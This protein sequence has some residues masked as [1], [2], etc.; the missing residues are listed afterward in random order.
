MTRAQQDVPQIPLRDGPAI[1]QLGYGTLALQPDREHSDANAEITASVVAEALRAGYRHLDSAQSYG[2]ERGVGRAIAESGIARDELYVA[3]KLAN[4]HHRPD[5]VR[6]SF[7]QTLERLGLD[8]L[9]LFLIHWPLPTL[10]DG[11]FVST[12]RAVAALVDDGRLRSAG[13]SNFLPE[14]L[15][16]IVEETGLV[17][18]VDQVE[19][20][21]Y[22]QNHETREAC[23]RLGI[24]VETHAPL[25]HNREPLSDPEIARIAA[26]HG[27]TPAQVILRWHVQLGDVSIPKSASPERMRENLDVFDFTLSAQEMETIAALDRGADGRVGPHPATYEG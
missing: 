12:W 23:E 4:P 6:R 13:V 16:R 18:V 5:D 20:H 15:D 8:H 11:D 10:Y 1:P 9:D 7:D 26:E 22:F 3:S 27:R 17:P 25:G 24:V 14:H 19:S 2:T 21:P